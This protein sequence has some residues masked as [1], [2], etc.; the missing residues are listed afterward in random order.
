MGSLVENKVVISK[1]IDLAVLRKLLLEKQNAQF[2]RKSQHISRLR[3]LCNMY[4]KGTWQTGSASP[5]MHVTMLQEKRKVCV[6]LLMG[7][8][9]L[10]VELGRFKKEEVTTTEQAL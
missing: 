3:F 8:L 6:N 10:E 1:E 2:Q 4:P 9:E 7:T 5:I